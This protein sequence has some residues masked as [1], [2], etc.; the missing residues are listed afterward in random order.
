MEVKFD[1]ASGM[2]ACVS[3]PIAVGKCSQKNTKFFCRMSAQLP[4][5]KFYSGVFISCLSFENKTTGNCL[6]LGWHHE[7]ERTWI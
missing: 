6:W 7:L 5:V 3:L 2:L 4:H 1:L